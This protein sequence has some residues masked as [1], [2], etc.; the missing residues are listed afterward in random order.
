VRAAVLHE[1][2]SPPVVEDVPVP[3]P[4]LDRLV[5][6]VTAATV[7]PLD[8]LY[9]SGRT[10]LGAPDLPYVPGVQGVG[11]APDGRRVWFATGA[12]A[13]GEDG[14]YAEVC[15]ADPTWFVP[16]PDG[17]DDGLAAAL[18]LSSVA[19]AGALERATVRPGESV[20]VL[21]ANGVVGR[22]AVQ[23]ARSSA[24]ECV[25]AVVR[26]PEGAAGANDLGADAVV[27]IGDDSVEEAAERLRAAAGGRLDAV[28]DPVWGHPAEVALA[29]LA[30]RGRLVNLGESAGPSVSLASAAVRSREIDVRG[31]TNL[32]LT[33]QAQAG[34]LMRVFALAAAG[35]LSMAFE[36]VPLEDA[37]Q[38]WRRQAERTAATRL[39]L[40]P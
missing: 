38:A 40:R 1:H 31:Y 26:G 5:V 22:I 19:A 20:A 15:A 16:V 32:T 8:L 2:G 6:T 9:A 12:G 7:Y 30:P 17:L 35:E 14:S 10:Y 18:G 3:E 13:S 33:P 27:E 28:V 25:L 37:T 23:L 34:H 36:S 29:A 24:A 11:V 4:R 21:G 39:V